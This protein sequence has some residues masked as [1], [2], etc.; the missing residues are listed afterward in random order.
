M[1][2]SIIVDPPPRFIS[3]EPC[4]VIYRKCLGPDLWRWRGIMSCCQWTIFRFRICNWMIYFYPLDRLLGNYMITCLIIRWCLFISF[5]DP[6]LSNISKWCTITI[7]SRTV[8]GKAMINS[9]HPL[10]P[11]ILLDSC[12]FCT[13][14]LQWGVF[15]LP[16]MLPTLV[17][18]MYMRLRMTF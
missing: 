12:R 18:Q 11:P 15:M 9:R 1:G 10:N 8:Q 14:V 5:I 4:T 2:Q 6:R 7:S 16:M 17:F 13:L 3:S